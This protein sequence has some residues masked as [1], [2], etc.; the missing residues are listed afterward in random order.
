MLRMTR[1]CSFLTAALVV[2]AGS[3]CWVPFTED[4]PPPLDD[5]DTGIDGDDDT[6]DDDDDSSQADDDDSTV[7]DDDDATDPPAPECAP[8]ATLLCGDV[9]A[10][11]NAAPGSTDVLEDY[12]CGSSGETGLEFAYSFTPAESGE[13][14]V[15]LSGLEAD[16][17][18]FV[19]AAGPAGEC[20][21]AGCV[22]SS[23]GVI[24][25]EEA[26]FTAVGAN[27]YYIVVDGYGD[28]ES[29]YTLE[30]DCDPNGGDDDDSTADDD[31]SSAGDD[32]DSTPP[33]CSGA[34]LVVPTVVLTD[35]SGAVTANFSSGNPVTVTVSL[36]NVGGGTIT[37]VYGTQCLFTTSVWSASGEPQGGERTC[38]G[39]FRTVDYVCGATPTTDTYDLPAVQTPSGVPLA[40]GTYE[41][42]VDTWDY[43]VVVETLTVP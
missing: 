15:R 21:P 25:T 20:D 39:L 36:E 8:A 11:N 40:S 27:T 12:S 7:V 3:G 35:P 41:L 4:E 38:T 10:G 32:D 18:L 5:D 16:L 23:A 24:D 28:A 22:A 26:T 37:G 31:D 14:A 13:V 42:H 2:F 33:P 30:I 17:D 34:P 29:P 19:L 6:A 1:L 9:L 43:G